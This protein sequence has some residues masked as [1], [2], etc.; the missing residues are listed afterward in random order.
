MEEM[1]ITRSFAAYRQR[2]KANQAAW[3]KAHPKAAGAGKAILKR[4]GATA[5]SG[6]G[7]DPAVERLLKRRS[8]VENKLTGKKTTRKTKAA[9]IAPTEK[10]TA[11][12]D[13]AAAKRK[14]EAASRK[15]ASET[16]RKE[17]QEKQRRKA[18][19]RKQQIQHQKEQAKQRKA[20]TAARK[21]KQAEQRKAE[22]ARRK[23]ETEEKKRPSLFIITIRYLAPRQEIDAAL[24][25]HEKFLQAYFQKKQF[26]F[27]GPQVPPTGSII[28]A[29]TKDRTSASRI[30]KASPL[31]KKKLATFE[32][33]EFRAARA[34][35]LH[36]TGKW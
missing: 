23:I 18:D 16:R 8:I 19:R 12:K 24:P 32:L 1:Q 17:Q 14:K 7:A 26:L 2:D 27:S 21:A 11:H 10:K 33:T 5:A 36:A 3:L 29:N 25:A 28:I 9:A 35:N 22:A 4:L 13:T 15:A 30:I 6:F 34:S 31:V 20:E